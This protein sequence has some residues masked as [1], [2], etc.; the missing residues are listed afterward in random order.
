MRKV[1][2]QLVKGKD[3]LPS[4]YPHIFQMGFMRLLRKGIYLVYGLPKDSGIWISTFEVDHITLNKHK[5]RQSF[6]KA[7][8]NRFAQEVM[9]ADQVIIGTILI[10]KVSVLL[11]QFYPTFLKEKV[12]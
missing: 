4:T 5:A 1:W 11:T 3:H 7:T 12:R 2:D 6:Q 8:V 9:A 10:E